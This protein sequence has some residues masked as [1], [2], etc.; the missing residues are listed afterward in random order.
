MHNG[1]R[2]SRTKPYH[3]DDPFQYGSGIFD[4]IGKWLKKSKLVSTLG[5]VIAPVAGVVSPALG[6]AVSAGTALAKQKGYGVRLAGEGHGRAPKSLNKAQVQCLM[7]GGGRLKMLRSGGVSLAALKKRY[8][9]QPKNISPAQWRALLSGRG[10]WGKGQ[11]IDFSTGTLLRTEPQGRRLPGPRSRGDVEVFGDIDD[12]TFTSEVVGGGTKKG[13]KRKTAR[14]AY[15]KGSGPVLPGRGV[16]LPGRGT[17]KGQ[18]R[19]T[20][21]KR[22]AYE[23]DIPFHAG[24]GVTLAGRGRAKRPALKKKY[25]I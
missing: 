9:N 21:S 2:M 24:D 6:A 13:M 25:Q 4:T 20:R 7:E 5:S 17:K 10:H 22:P 11:N 3:H 14:R 18:K 12:L 15:K 23:P 19:K 16:S 1:K 8:R